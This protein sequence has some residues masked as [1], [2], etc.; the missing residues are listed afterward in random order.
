M[1]YF[2]LHFLVRGNFA[3]DFIT[4]D[5]PTGSVGIIVHFPY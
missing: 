3:A 2:C 1:L 5:I 4:I